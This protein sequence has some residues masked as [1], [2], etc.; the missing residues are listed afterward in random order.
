MWIRLLIAALS[1]GIAAFAGFGFA[2]SFEPGAGIGWKLGYAGLFLTAGL[3][4][5]AALRQRSGRIV[6]HEP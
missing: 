3:G 4:V 5:A 6:K 2:A 1:L